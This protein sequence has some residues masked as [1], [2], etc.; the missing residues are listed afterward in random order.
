M[1]ID[2]TRARS[3]ADGKAGSLAAVVAEGSLVI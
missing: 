1:G 3:L 2:L